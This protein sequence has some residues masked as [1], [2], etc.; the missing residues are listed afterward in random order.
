MIILDEEVLL[1][2]NL[3]QSYKLYKMFWLILLITIILDSLT[4][5]LFMQKDGIHFEAN[6]LIRWLA[7]HMGI[8]PG[9]IVGKFLQLVAAIGFSALSLKYSR[10]ILLLL[11]LLNLLAIYHN[12]EYL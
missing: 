12:L 8:A 2:K 9:V 6:F 4:T 3:I 11:A 10:A 5:M 1:K 7:L